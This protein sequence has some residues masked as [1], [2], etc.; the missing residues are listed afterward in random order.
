MLHTLSKS[1]LTVKG[2][3]SPSPA[4]LDQRPQVSP[5]LVARAAKLST[6][7]TKQ[8]TNAGISRALPPPST[9]IG[10]TT[11]A[12]QNRP[13][14]GNMNAAPSSDDHSPE[15][16]PLDELL[17]KLFEQLPHP[18]DFMLFLKAYLKLYRTLRYDGWKLDENYDAHIIQLSR[19][20]EELEKT[21]QCVIRGKIIRP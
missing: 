3:E 5:H 17:I 9:S 4:Q 14:K 15:E 1:I 11:S 18:K 2:V 16:G 8:N 20:I 21:G 10:G 6:S 19:I 13:R 12:R 7:S